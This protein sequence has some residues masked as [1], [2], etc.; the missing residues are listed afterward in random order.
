MEY[1]MLSLNRCAVRMNLSFRTAMLMHSVEGEPS[2]LPLPYQRPTREYQNGLHGQRDS[3]RRLKTGMREGNASSATRPLSGQAAGRAARPR[4]RWR[5]CAR[6]RRLS[7]LPEIRRATVSG[8]AAARAQSGERRQSGGEGG[9]RQRLWY[10]GLRRV[11]R[12]GRGLRRP[13][14]GDAGKRGEREER[15]FRE[16]AFGRGLGRGPSGG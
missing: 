4:A 6:P 3:S 11:R 2:H 16:A 9:E 10:G 13:T 8:A 1:R 12:R 7:V 15:E 5:A 14:A